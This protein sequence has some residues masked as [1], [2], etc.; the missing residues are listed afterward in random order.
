M[1]ILQQFPDYCYS[2]EDYEKNVRVSFNTRYPY[3]RQN[4]F[5]A[6]DLEQFVRHWKNLDRNS[7]R[8]ESL[9]S[10]IPQIEIETIFQNNLC[11][12]D[13]YNTFQY[14]NEKFKKGC[15]LQIHENELKTY[16]PFS[17]QS[18]R[19]E[20][21][22]FISID[23]RFETLSSMM[24]YLS[25]IDTTFPFDE[26]KN[27][28]DVHCW[29]GNNGLV[30]FEYPLSEK[31]NGYN[32]LKDMFVTLTNERDVP[33]VDFFMNKRDY[34][35]LRNDGM[36]AYDVFFGDNHPLISHKYDKYVPILSMNT[37]DGFADI[38]IPTWEDWRR[39]SYLH[40]GKLFGKDYQT[41]EA[42]EDF[43]KIIWDDKIPTAIW[44][45]ASTGLGT[46]KSDNIRLFVYDYG[47]KNE[48]DTD[49]VPFVDVKMTKWNLRPRKHKNNPYLRTILKEDFDMVTSPYMTP[50]EQAQYKYVLHLPGHTCAYRLSHEMFMGSVILFYPSSN[51]LWFTHLL[52]PWV[53][54]VPI[55]KEFDEN[56]IRE[57]IRWCKEND[58]KCQ[59]I[60]KN[61]RAFADKH[62]TREGILNFLQTLLCFLSRNNS[63]EYNKVSLHEQQIGR[64]EEKIIEYE[65]NYIGQ[66]PL[67]FF[68]RNLFLYA[69]KYKNYY[70]YHLNKAG[71]FEDFLKTT[72]IQENIINSKKTTINLY[73]YENFKWLEKIVKKDWKRD[74][75]HQVFVSYYYINQLRN[76]CP[77]FIHTFFHKEEENETKVYMEYVETITLD[78][79]LREQGFTNSTQ[80]V[81][82]DFRL[83]DLVN[84]WVNVCCALQVAQDYCG[85]VHMDLY[86]WNILIK[87]NTKVISYK[88]LGI[89][90]NFRYNPILIDYGNCHVVDNGFH[91][92]NTTPFQLSSFSDVMCMIITSL[93]VFLS[94]VTLNEQDRKLLFKIID[95]L[96]SFD[97]FKSHQLK[98]IRDIKDFLK[99]HKKFSKMLNNIS[100]FS[101][102][103]PLDF[104]YY[105]YNKKCLD[106]SQILFTKS[107]TNIVVFP[108]VFQN[109][110]D[111]LLF[112]G[113]IFANPTKYNY[114]V[115]DI[116]QLSRRIVITLKNFM[117]QLQTK[118][119]FQTE[120]YNNIVSLFITK[121]KRY[122]FHVQ[123]TQKRKIWNGLNSS[124]ILD[125]I[126]NENSTDNTILLHGIELLQKMEL[127]N[128]SVPLLKTHLCKKCKD[129]KSTVTTYFFDIIKMVQFSKEEFNIFLLKNQSV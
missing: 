71:R 78:K 21:G 48:C 55:E 88:N 10:S 61:A 104:V 17:R 80:K 81:K 113:E 111:Q 47:Q 74:D 54:Y 18:F 43:D 115:D 4:Y 41:Y 94:K 125:E 58:T 117:K 119:Q 68:Q 27:N 85:F 57:K 90:T 99:E 31:D 91:Y 11:I 123:K 14:I 37:C 83:Q 62:L 75:L 109:L 39:V 97:I 65:Q 2:K 63:I 34:P 87:D 30:R 93:D 25:E 86:P 126:L 120:Y 112:F 121:F 44:R 50:L 49:G 106:K 69:F 76:I 98:T 129:G 96:V 103:R 118:N 127:S 8:N 9:Y 12:H 3:F 70:F 45:G 114:P 29:Y 66:F 33:D 84:I 67:D 82:K 64:L 22:N 15:F 32:I 128:P 1:N 108:L 26:K 24:K 101:N 110:Q 77:N 28:R 46:T 79:K 7:L 122:I 52:E 38:A 95:F 124:I 5:T 16:I 13:Y 107:K 102:K 60:V 51:R 23:P 19:N 72:L 100:S 42:H 40:D 20:W 105:L 59:E 73:Q 92:Y 6:G 116:F 36:E 89:E 56:E 35:I 53:H